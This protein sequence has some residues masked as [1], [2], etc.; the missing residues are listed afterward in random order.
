MHDVF[1]ADSYRKHEQTEEPVVSC[2]R[3]YKQVAKWGTAF[4]GEFKHGEQ[5]C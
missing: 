4:S 3:E 1:F 5:N 2:D